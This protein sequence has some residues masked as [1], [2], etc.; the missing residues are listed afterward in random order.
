MAM[1]TLF[2]YRALKEQPL[3]EVIPITN[4]APL[5][6]A[7][8]GIIWLGEDANIFWILGVFTG[9]SAILL[10]AF[11]SK[12]LKIKSAPLLAMVLFGLMSFSKKIVV[13][14]ISPFFAAFLVFLF[15][16]FFYVVLFIRRTKNVL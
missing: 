13:G 7:L 5:I 11:P 3:S 8:L 6:P 1:G 12:K 16:M 2:L 14:F 4:L 9:I 10:L 15:A